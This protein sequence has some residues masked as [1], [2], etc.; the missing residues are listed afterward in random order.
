MGI[1]CS[2]QHSQLRIQSAQSFPYI[3]SLLLHFC[4][5]IRSGVEWFIRHIKVIFQHKQ[6]EVEVGYKVFQHRL[7][8]TTP[9]EGVALDNLNN[10][11]INY[12]FAIMSSK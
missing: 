7:C 12:Y 2:Q 11:L 1:A 9:H 5:H 4:I 10:K 6:L 3:L 8:T